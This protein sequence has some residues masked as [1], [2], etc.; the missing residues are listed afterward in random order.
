MRRGID[1]GTVI[2]KGGGA[3]VGL[4]YSEKRGE[5]SSLVKKKRKKDLI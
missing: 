4:F 2:R 5:N 1:L 3:R